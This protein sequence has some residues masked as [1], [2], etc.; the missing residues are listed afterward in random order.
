MDGLLSSR[1]NPISCD[2]E[3]EASGADLNQL[4][5]WAPMH[6]HQLPF[7]VVEKD[8]K[9][10][11]ACCRVSLLDVVEAD[12]QQFPHIQNSKF[13][14]FNGNKK[15]M[16]HKDARAKKFKSASN[17][18]N[19]FLCFSC[20]GLSLCQNVEVLGKQLQFTLAVRCCEPN[21]IGKLPLLL[22]GLNGICTVTRQNRLE[23]TVV[24]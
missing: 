11:N 5:T 21:R 24:G 23:I 17:R 7:A 13:L 8:F 1:P 4:L 10:H 6:K 12:Q 22:T 2:T 18:D 15:F 20:P 16:S 9:S 14:A 3:T 19:R